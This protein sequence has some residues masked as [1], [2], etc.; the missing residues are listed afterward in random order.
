M[1]I[2]LLVFFPGS[3]YLGLAPPDIG[4]VGG[5]Q[6]AEAS[7]ENLLVDGVIAGLDELE[8]GLK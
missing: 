4:D 1:E 7:S 2:F 5:V 6:G 8:R 3:R